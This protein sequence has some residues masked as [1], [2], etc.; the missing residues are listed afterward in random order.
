MLSLYLAG[1]R[2]DVAVHR[3]PWILVRRPGSAAGLLQLEVTSI[4]EHKNQL[5][6][7]WLQLC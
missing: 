6:L 7:Q 5:L 2:C 3:H 4:R 1:Y